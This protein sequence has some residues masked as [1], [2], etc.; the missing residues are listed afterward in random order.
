MT[1][2]FIIITL[3][4]LIFGAILGFASLKLKVE[5]DPNVDNVVILDANHTL[6][7]FAMEMTSQ[8]V[9]LEVNLLS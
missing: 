5:A 2:L 8:N 1:L 7:L 4:A 3:L 6:K 9:F